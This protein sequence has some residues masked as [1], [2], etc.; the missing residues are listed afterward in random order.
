[1][2]RGPALTQSIFLSVEEPLL[3]R[4]WRG[5]VGLGLQRVRA[6]LGVPGEGTAVGR[7]ADTHPGGAVTLRER[8]RSWESAKPASSPAGVTGFTR[9]RAASG[10]KGQA[11]LFGTRV[12]KVVFLKTH[13]IQP[14]GGCGSASAPAFLSA[15]GFCPVFFLP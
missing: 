6:P 3:A 11:G 10:F 7:Q 4:W 8:V 15:L 9:R 14:V 5:L 12:K 13:Q 2:Q 1:M